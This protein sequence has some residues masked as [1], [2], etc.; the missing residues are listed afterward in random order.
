[1]NPSGDRS[2]FLGRL[3]DFPARLA[4]AAGAATG[5]PVPAG[6][7]T[8]EQVVRHLVAVETDVH[9][10]RLHDLATLE[11][12]SWT[13]QEPGPWSGQPG[14]DLDGVLVRFAE[15]RAETVAAYRALDEAGW[16]RTGR[17]ATFGALDADGLLRLAVDHDEEHLAG[18]VTP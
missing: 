7:W 1:V 17:H 2:T 5:R 13:W 12:P 8:V 4:P 6:E 9:H 15:L 3:A 18:L 10:S 14:L 16:S 11:T